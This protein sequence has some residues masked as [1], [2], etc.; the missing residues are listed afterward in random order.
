SLNVEYPG[1]SAL[2]IPLED[3]GTESKTLHFFNR[4]VPSVLLGAPYDEWF[5]DVLSKNVYL[6]RSPKEVSRWTSGNH[7][8]VTPIQFPD[9]YPFLLA[10]QESLDALNEKLE[11]PVTMDRFRP[12]IVIS[13]VKPYGEDQWTHLRIEDVTFLSVKA[14]SRCSIVDVDPQT[15]TSSKNVTRALKSYRMKDSKILFGMNL[16]HTNQGTIYEKSIIELQ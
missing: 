3:W 8:P 5:S 15:G 6:A 13:G 12:N 9:G 7:G 16:S 2:T 11:T 4:P 1:F 14:C 10:S